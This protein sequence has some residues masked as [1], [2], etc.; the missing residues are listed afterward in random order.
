M[1]QDVNASVAKFE[2]EITKLKIENQIMK[3]YIRRQENLTEY[4]L[5]FLLTQRKKCCLCQVEMSAFEFQRHL[6]IEQESVVCPLSRVSYVPVEFLLKCHE[7]VHENASAQSEEINQ[8]DGS[9]N[10]I[11]EDPE[12]PNADESFDLISIEDT[13]SNHSS[14]LSIYSV[15]SVEMVD[16]EESSGDRSTSITKIESS[17]KDELVEKPNRI[18]SSSA[19][20]IVSRENDSN[21]IQQLEPIHIKIEP[22]ELLLEEEIKKEISLGEIFIDDT[23]T[24]LPLDN[25]DSVRKS[26][27][28]SSSYQHPQ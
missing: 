24:V 16:D 13:A 21:T 10:S 12:E 9:R 5:N 28:S 7:K 25:S 23:T 8:Y 2:D 1:R 14:D 22:G 18:F 3:D 20:E 19:I 6:C 17:D 4:K 15:L 26:T 11:E 27:N